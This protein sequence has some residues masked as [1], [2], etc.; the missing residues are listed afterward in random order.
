MVTNNNENNNN[1]NNGNGNHNNGNGTFRY[2]QTPGDDTNT[3]IYTFATHGMA[4]RWDS[5]VIQAKN[6]MDYA[7]GENTF[8]GLYGNVAEFRR[9][10]TTGSHSRHAG[11][12]GV[13]R[14]HDD[15]LHVVTRIANEFGWDYVPSD[16]QWAY[17]DVFDHMT[18]P[19]WAMLYGNDI[20]AALTNRLP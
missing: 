18:R 15:F 3:A 13:L 10:V 4:N 6:I 14:L 20:P 9:A 16:V 17:H 12:I 7:V 8:L 1:H 2:Y 5:A 19:M 11:A